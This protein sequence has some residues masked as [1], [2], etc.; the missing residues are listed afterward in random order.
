MVQINK[1]AKVLDEQYEEKQDTSKF[2]SSSSAALRKRGKILLVTAY[3]VPK[4]TITW[5]STASTPQ[6]LFTFTKSK[7]KSSATFRCIASSIYNTVRIT[8]F[9]LNSDCQLTYYKISSDTWA[10]SESYY[11]NFVGLASS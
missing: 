7:F 4:S 3:L 5:P 8:R 2:T 10:T 6:V 1:N 9:E 11:V